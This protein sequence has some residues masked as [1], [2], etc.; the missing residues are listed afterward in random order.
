MKELYY[1]AREY[2][3]QGLSVVALDINKRSI[4]AWKGWQE[5]IATPGELDFM[6]HHRRARGI[7]IVCGQVSGNL[8]VIDVDCKNDLTGHL[9]K[10]LLDEM[11]KAC[12]DLT[13]NLVVATTLSGGYHLLYRCERI[14]ASR[15]LANRPLTMAEKA[16]H[17]KEKMRVL[18]ETRG[19]ASYVAAYPTPGY[20]FIQKSI[21][22]VP[23]ITPL[24]RELL[25]QCCQRFN[26]VEVLPLVRRKAPYSFP[27]VNSPFDAF[28]KHGDI[29]ALLVHHGWSVVKQTTERTY[30]KRPG[31]SASETS[32]N[33]NH[34]LGLF[35]VFSTS[36]E[37][38]PSTGYRPAIVFAILECNGSFREAAKKLLQMGFGQRYSS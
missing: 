19:K 23:L 14:E 30:F 2:A 35:S 7:G 32:G 21:H 10:D 24:Q 16:L 11:N 1:A 28:N 4:L 12:A 31:V 26:Q 18:I 29:V 38:T 34:E 17:S 9:F 37:F 25:L 3:A 5:R 20:K 13:H 36:T 6:F 27:Q 33:F 15:K 22:S 8:E